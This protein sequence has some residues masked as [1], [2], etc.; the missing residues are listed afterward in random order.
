MNKLRGRV[1]VGFLGSALALALFAQMSEQACGQSA[2][3]ANPPS[4]SAPGS[5]RG[6]GPAPFT[7]T[8][9]VL[10]NGQT[11][12]TFTQFPTTTVLPYAPVAIRPAPYAIPTSINSL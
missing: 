4:R 11:P 2:P 3:P 1:T 9:T 10:S 6:G 5:L 8:F 7:T 12:A